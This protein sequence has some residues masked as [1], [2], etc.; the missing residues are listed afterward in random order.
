MASIDLAS[1][2]LASIG[3]ASIGLASIGL[4]SIG[5]ASI[6][7]ASIGLASIGLASIGLASIGLASIGLASIGLASI[8]LASIGGATAGS[9]AAAAIDG[10]TADSVFVKFS[11]GVAVPEAAT[12]SVRFWLIS[13]DWT[14]SV[15]R[16]AASGDGALAA[17]CESESGGFVFPPQI[18]Q[19]LN[20]T[21]ASSI[22]SGKKT[23]RR[24]VAD[25]S[26]RS[27]SVCSTGAAGRGCSW[28]PGK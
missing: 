18:N 13:V 17:I 16:P 28:R 20:E 19:L 25:S 1:I 9:R 12:G 7:L 5:L 22:M 23:R 4:A 11:V 2:G 8:G 26:V 21:I 3:L 14:G 10:R 6:G 27:P 15:G 24:G